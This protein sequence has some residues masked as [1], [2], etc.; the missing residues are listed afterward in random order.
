ML[1][2]LYDLSQNSLSEVRFPALFDFSLAHYNDA[3]NDNTFLD[4]ITKLNYTLEKSNGLTSEFIIIGDY[5]FQCTEYFITILENVKEQLV[6]TQDHQTP[7]SKPTKPHKKKK[8]SNQSAS[9]LNVYIDP[10]SI[11]CNDKENS[12]LIK[13]G[14]KNLPENKK[15]MVDYIFS[16]NAN[17]KEFY[18]AEIIT[19]YQCYI[20]HFLD[21]LALEYIPDLHELIMDYSLGKERSDKN[22][23]AS[24]VL[25]IWSS[26]LQKNNFL[27]F[28]KDTIDVLSKFSFEF[29]SPDYIFTIID[30]YSNF[31]YLLTSFSMERSIAIW[32]EVLPAY[33]EKFISESVLSDD[34]NNDAIDVAKT[35][36]NKVAEFFSLTK[37]PFTDTHFESILDVYIQTW[38]A[39]PPVFLLMFIHGFKDYVFLGNGKTIDFKDQCE[40][41]DL[42]ENIC[43]RYLTK[44]DSKL[45]LISLYFTVIKSIQQK[46]DEV[47]NSQEILDFVYSFPLAEKFEFIPMLFYFNSTSTNNYLAKIFINH[48]IEELRKFNA[49]RNPS[50]KDKANLEKLLYDGESFLFY[51]LNYAEFFPSKFFLEKIFDIIV[52]LPSYNKKIL[53]LLMLQ[54]VYLVADIEV[55]AKV[56][57]YFLKE[58]KLIENYKSVAFGTV[59]PV[60]LQSFIP[61]LI[62]LVNFNGTLEWNSDFKQV[63]SS[64]DLNSYFFSFITGESAIKNSNFPLNPSFQTNYINSV[65]WSMREVLLNLGKALLFLNTGITIK[66]GE[67]LF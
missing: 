29:E 14:Y 52:D 42:V 49:K 10:F 62:A 45:Q 18:Y 36:G 67:Y 37:L 65:E 43:Q 61:L 38:I 3:L 4:F 60:K 46:L 5:T 33:I 20:F 47:D 44:E 1:A 40:I 34:L 54:R 58:A 64:F 24:K 19:V 16:I 31:S 35:L 48:S 41:F 39:S 17:I 55:P 12:P 57:N 9:N 63:F 7:V 51:A 13:N 26:I 66:E 28:E 56:K 22:L 11:L 21:I 2:S 53:Y 50:R 25:L 59:D 8:K 6:P 32:N 23:Y 15:I 30:F 27:D